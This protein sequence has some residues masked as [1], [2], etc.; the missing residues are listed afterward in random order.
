MSQ[1][2]IRLDD[3]AL[4]EFIGTE[5]EGGCLVRRKDV[6]EFERVLKKLRDQ[7]RRLCGRWVVRPGDAV[8]TAY[9]ANRAKERR[10]LHRG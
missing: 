8:V 6:Q 9:H 5:V 4:A 7:A 1:R 3:L 10:L 2:G